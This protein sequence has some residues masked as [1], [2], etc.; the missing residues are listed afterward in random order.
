MSDRFDSEYFDNVDDLIRAKDAAF[1]GVVNRKNRLQTIRQFTNMMATLTDE[2]AERLN[3]SEI[4][5]HGLTYAAMLQNESQLTAM[6]NMTNALVEVIVDTDSPEQDMVTGQRV[7]AAINKHAIHYRG[8]FANF[9]RKV[10]GEIVIAG[11]IPV[12]Q[13]ECYGW[14]PEPKIDMFFP[15]ETSLDSDKVPYG[16]DPKELTIGDL[17]S[18]KNSVKN[19]DG[20][21]I[22][23]NNIEKLI[24]RIKD[25]VKN[26]TTDGST[27]VRLEVSRSVRDDDESLNK[28]TTLPAWW[29]YEVKHVTDKDSKDFGQSYVSATLFVDAAT[30]IDLKRTRTDEN[31]GTGAI[32]AYKEKAYSSPEDWLHLVCV[33]A[34]IGGVKNL[35]TLKGVAEMQY[36][37]GVDME[38]LLNLIIEGE[39]IRARPKMKLTENVDV[40]ALKKWDIMSDIY[41]PAGIEEAQFRGNSSGLNNPLSILNQ[42]AAGI[43][44]SSVSNGG[45]GGDELRVQA[46]ARERNSSNV[47][48]N[49]LSDAY[50]HLDAI[51]DNV[52]Y[53]L[54]AGETKP[55]TP[56]F[57]EIMCVRDELKKYGIDFKALAERKYGRFKNIRVRARR[58][59]GNGDRVQQVATAQWLMENSVNYAPQTRALAVYNA[60]LL[61]TQDPDLTDQL[62]KVPQAII[63]AQKVTAE[64]E[65][66]VVSRR[67]LLGEIIP[68]AADDVHQDHVP[69]HLKD[70]QALV[71]LN[72]L[73]PWTRK[74]VAIFAAMAEHVNQHL[75]VLLENPATHGEGVQFLQMFQQI[76]QA[77]Q[78]IVQTVDEQEGSEVNQLTPKEMADIEI[79]RGQLELEGRKLGLKS[80]EMDRLEMQREAR[81]ALL[82][83]QQAVREINEDRRLNLDNKRIDSQAERQ[84]SNTEK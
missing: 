39:K 67:A 77:A 66:D 53:R 9:W 36:P 57:N 49:R 65:Y 82:R 43:T 45:G 59:I 35:D 21:Y 27:G 22:D 61:Q 52:V 75:G 46:L 15:K 60:T 80:S 6:V 83:R 48:G 30:A 5:N 1:M 13:D 16:F 69:I 44:T 72:D 38:E 79:K 58:T 32:I 84:K 2:E 34:E 4:T 78:S 64:N 24:Q 56:G 51:L 25:N 23:K 33:D 37:S 11:G 26:D 70:M 8:R 20:S 3:R 62:V 55:G 71:A 31:G 14:L 50:N 29:F 68:I 54:L 74:T 63:N 18:L 42:T 76:G 40:N 41:M 10:S 17:L 7:S 73:E 47:Q 12:V 81:A 19:G 28:S